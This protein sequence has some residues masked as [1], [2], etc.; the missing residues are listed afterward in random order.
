MIFNF[1]DLLLEKNVQKE[2]RDAIIDVVVRPE[3]TEV[4]REA[5]LDPNKFVLNE[6]SMTSFMTK[7]ITDRE[8]DGAL[9]SIYYDSVTEQDIYRAGC[10]ITIEPT[11]VETYTELFKLENYSSGNR[12]WLV[13]SNGDWIQ[14]PGIDLFDISDFDRR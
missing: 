14:G 9:V 13:F 2:D 6:E 11:T 8:E 1:S 7:P 5:S 10:R 4:I 3:I 12:E